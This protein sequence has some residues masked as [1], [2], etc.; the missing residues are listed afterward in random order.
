MFGI[1]I[2]PVGG[3]TLFINQERALAEMPASLRG[4]IEGKRAIHSAAGGYAPEGLYG[5]ADKQSNRSMKVVSSEAARATQLHP[6]IVRHPETGI[7]RL[8]G[9]IGYIIGIEGMSADDSLAL[10]TELY[11]WQIQ[12][13]FQ[14][15]HQWQADML[16]MWDNR[17]V[18]H[19]ATGGY[20]G[21]DRLLHRTTVGCR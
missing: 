19:R 17:S 20:D 3:N 15:S 11:Q 10:L 16:V 4:K 5:D 7:E 6:L 14:Y 18:L 21:W 12:D 8:F 2:P 9:C 13:Q 1:T